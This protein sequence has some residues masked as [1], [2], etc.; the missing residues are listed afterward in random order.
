MNVQKIAINGTEQL[1]IDESLTL[2][3]FDTNGL[4]RAKDLYILTSK[5]NKIPLIVNWPQNR[6]DYTFLAGS[7]GDIIS[8]QSFPG[9]KYSEKVFV[10]NG[11]RIE[12]VCAQ[13]TTGVA[14]INCDE[15][16]TEYRMCLKGLG[17]PQCQYYY[18]DV[19]GRFPDGSWFVFSKLKDDRFS[20]YI[21]D[22]PNIN[23][24]NYR[25]NCIDLDV[26]YTIESVIL[27]GT[28]KLF[29]DNHYIL[30][31]NMEVIFPIFSAGHIIY[32]TSTNNA[33]WVETMDNINF[34]EDI[35]LLSYY[36]LNSSSYGFYAGDIFDAYQGFLHKNKLYNKRLSIL[37]DSISTFGTPDQANSTGTWTYPGNRCR[38]PQDNLFTT[39]ECQYWYKLLTKYNMVLA[40]NESWAGSLVSWD[41]QTESSDIGRH[42]HIASTTRISHLNSPDII[43]IHAGT[44]DFSYGVALGTIDTTSPEN[45]TTE[46]IANLPV[47]TFASAYR[48]MLIRIQKQYPL[49]KIIVLLPNYISSIA[50]NNR[51]DDYLEIIK[52]VCDLFGV[53]WIDLR[54]SGFT[55]FNKGNYLPDGIHPNDAGMTMIYKHLCKEVFDELSKNGI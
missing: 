11:K 45:L 17:Q 30:D 25:I 16:E 51:L 5:Q 14:L 6:E 12:F 32:H 47:N 10:P 2:Q 28:L 55:Y 49:A 13:G 41:G 38:Y 33:E 29:R 3:S 26:S 22:I 34:G 9:W 8:P 19:N 36:N 18:F 15:N 43:I 24:S 7:Y 21:S 35:R 27:T 31:Y 52:N 37:G 39:V 48:T 42:K 44:N 23:L 53:K 54:T 4:I 46:E 50:F 40:R 1:R 20:A